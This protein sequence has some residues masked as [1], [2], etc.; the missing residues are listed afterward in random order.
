MANIS[1]VKL[2]SG[3]TYDI[4]D[5][6]AR[7][8]ISQLQASTDFLGITTTAL[9]DQATTN[10]ITV[11]SKSVTAVNGNIVVYGN[12]EFVFNGTKWFEFG[13]LSTLGTLATKNSVTL[14]KGTSTNVLGS[15]STFKVKNK[16]V[17]FAGGTSDTVLGTGTTFTASTPTVTVTPTTTNIKATATGTSVGANGTAAAITGFGTHSTE[18]F[19]TTVTPDKSKKLV[20][21]SI[22]PTNGTESV[23]KVTKT[24][25][26]LV[27]TSIPNVTS[28]G[29][30]DTWAFAMGTGDDAETLII[31]GG[32]GTAATLGTAIT[33]ATGSVASTGT[34]SDIVTAV[35][36]SDKTVAKAGTAVT[37][38]TG[39]ATTAGTGAVVVSDVTTASDDAITALGTPTTANALTGVKITAQPTITLATGAT[40]GTGVISV[41]TGISSA[42]ATAPTVTAG[43]NDEVTAVTGVGTAALTSDEITVTPSNVGVAKHSDLSITVS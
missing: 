28:A 3:N 30:A 41:A 17:S 22:T 34:G 6:G 24:A 8:L 15:G 33:A 25:S 21:T 27:T 35:T 4:V 14:N 32:N 42:T 37:V 26:K 20:T 23:S 43:D 7:E 16:A 9:T 18:S 39:A 10:P 36:I 13:D 19:V 11:D 2:P 1:K 12:K 38:A 5:A 40:A 29:S 31:S